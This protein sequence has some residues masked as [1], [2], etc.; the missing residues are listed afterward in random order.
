MLTMALCLSWGSANAQTVTVCD[1]TATNGNIPVYGYSCD[2]YGTT[3]EFVI[4]ASTE[5]MSSMNGQTITSMT[6]YLYSSAAEA[7][8]ATFQVYMKEISET[9]LSSTTGPGSCNV[10]YTGT[11]DATGSEMNDAASG[12]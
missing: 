6:F 4:P 5:G 3:C 2:T 1:G 11:L 8:T 10:V 9:T 7:W 12:T